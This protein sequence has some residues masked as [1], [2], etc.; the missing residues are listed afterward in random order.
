[1]SFGGKAAS[2]AAKRQERIAQ[3]QATQLQRLFEREREEFGGREA[4]QRAEIERAAAM[5]PA[6]REQLFGRG[7]AALGGPGTRL[8]PRGA[9][10]RFAEERAR[11]TA[12][13]Q[14]ARAPGPQT[15]KGMP[16]PPDVDPEFFKRIIDRKDAA[17]Q[18]IYGLSL[19][20]P[21]AQSQP[22]FQA[23]I[24]EAAD[25][26]RQ[27]T[28]EHGREPGRRVQ[29]LE[30][31]LAQLRE[32]RATERVPSRPF[33]VRGPSGRAVM[34][35]GQVSFELSP[36]MKQVADQFFG[37]LQG[38][39]PEVAAQT[40]LDLF[41]RLARPEERRRRQELES[42]LFGRG[43]LGATGGAEQLRALEEAQKQA[44]LERVLTTIGTSRQEQQRLLQ[45][46]MGIEERP[47]Q[48]FGPQM[49]QR[50]AVLETLMGQQLG[51]ELEAPERRMERLMDLYRTGAEQRGPLFRTGAEMLG[52]GQQGIMG[53]AQRRGQVQTERG[54]G[55]SQL[56]GTIA[57]A[58]AAPFTGGLSAGL[59]LG[60][61]GQAI[62]RAARGLFTPRSPF[63]GIPGPHPGQLFT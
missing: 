63:Q 3:Q 7:I 38:Y 58:G 40:E 26:A 60:Q 16:I 48:L 55:L 5:G 20:S 36:R 61:A 31:R 37:A 29:E 50:Q 28:Q 62:G 51:A 32:P 9:A 59:G 24:Q 12:E 6:Q 13:L 21:V 43:M 14:A 30:S 39:R 54:A 22:T 52:A 47:V 42:T 15:Y 17:H 10:E 34:R 49:A 19:F 57:S 35:E 8:V 46:L 4:L 45:N 27:L 33:E 23:E 18:Q 1:M 44:D 53:A 56:L 2:K 41:R 25:Q 11:L